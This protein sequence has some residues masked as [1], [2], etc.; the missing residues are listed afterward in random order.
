VSFINR[1]PTGLLGFLGIKNFGRNPDS[2]APTLAPV[3]ELQDLYLNSAPKWQV[4]TAAGVAAGNA[5]VFAPPPQEV[6]YVTNYSVYFET[7]GGGALIVSLGIFGQ[8]NTDFCALSE[9]LALGASTGSQRIAPRPFWLMPGEKCGYLV[10]GVA[11]VAN[12][13]HGMRYA[14][15]AV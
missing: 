12:A 5:I 14:A 2:L 4:S 10:H 6:W 15:L 13:T 11:G 1:Q 8:T 7:A 3:W 9:T